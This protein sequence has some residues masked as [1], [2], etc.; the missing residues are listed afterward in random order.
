ML[1][2][3][4]LK[5]FFSFEKWF[6]IRSVCG[7]VNQINYAV[8]LKWLTFIH[9]SPNQ[10]HQTITLKTNDE[11]ITVL[12]P[13]LHFSRLIWIWRDFSSG[14]KGVIYMSKPMN[15]LD[16]L[17]VSWRSDYQVT[18]TIVTTVSLKFWSDWTFCFKT[19]IPRNTF[20]FK[21]LNLAQ[22]QYFWQ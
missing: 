16:M 2:N 6:S 1:Y 15:C 21:W 10:I 18:V 17:T 3:M 12:S 22:Q 5:Y 14:F 20:T 8:V 11:K 4:L 19:N 9:S 7:L 13:A